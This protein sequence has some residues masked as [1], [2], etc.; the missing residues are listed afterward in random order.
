MKKVNKQTKNNMS[1]N[2]SGN[3]TVATYIGNKCISKK[4]YHNKGALALY[5]FLANCLAGNF[6]TAY[7]LRPFK[8][9]LLSFKN[10]DQILPNDFDLTEAFA[11]DAIADASDF[12]Q[13]AAAPEIK[14]TD[15][16]DSCGCTVTLNFI[17][18]YDRIISEK[19]H[20]VAIYGPNIN[21]AKEYC[22]YYLLTQ[23]KA[24]DLENTGDIKET[25]LTEDDQV[26]E[27]LQ[28][29][30]PIVKDPYEENTN[31][32]LAVEWSLNLYNK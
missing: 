6:P 17:F 25:Y 19:A 13:L 29:W 18:V 12:I 7:N 15:T 32:I 2:Y 1:I 20:I 26:S 24:E 31:K 11:T 27:I 21:D 9:K 16:K 10:A 23:Q 14:Y 28:S 30:D 3:V 22:A 4:A 8:I 5:R